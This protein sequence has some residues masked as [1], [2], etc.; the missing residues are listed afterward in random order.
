HLL[1]VGG[2]GRG[3]G[4]EAVDQPTTRFVGAI[5]ESATKR[6]VQD[7]SRMPPL[8]PRIPKRQVIRGERS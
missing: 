4:V 5:L 6:L 3:E 2:E 1:G 8:S 7:C